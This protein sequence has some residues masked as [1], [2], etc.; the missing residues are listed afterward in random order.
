MAKINPADAEAQ[1]YL[2]LQRRTAPACRAADLILITVLS[3]MIAVMGIAIFILPPSSFSEDENRSLTTFPAFSLGALASGEWT[4]DV[5]LFYSDQFPVRRMMVQLKAVCELAQLKGQNNGVILGSGGTLIKRLEYNDTSI[6]ARNLAAVDDL[7]AV[8]EGDGIPVELAVAPRA[9][10]VLCDELPALYGA[11]RSDAIWEEI[12]AHQSDAARYRD[13]LRELSVAGEYVWYRTDHHWTTDGAYAAY[14]ELG[15]QLGYTPYPASDF[16][17][18]VVSTEFYG[19]T[20]SS[21]GMYFVEPDTMCFYRY[22]GDEGYVVENMLTGSRLDGFYDTSY[23]DGKDKYSA[24]IGGNNAHVRVCRADGD[25]ADKPTLVL[26][27]DSYAHSLVPF[28]ARHYRLEIIDLRSYTGS[29]AKLAREKGA[30][31]V[32]VLTGV[33]NLATS[34]SLTLLRYGLTSAPANN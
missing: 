9:I 18:V 30:C 19:T 7:R 32:L 17:R 27:K 25:D 33:D 6:T 20:Y 23:L 24:F 15:R 3:V 29:V 26:V 2:A 13:R 5:T 28:L 16:Q 14:V 4:A 21:S 31:G 1:K 34:D 12:V 10:D 11:D 22:A 8:L